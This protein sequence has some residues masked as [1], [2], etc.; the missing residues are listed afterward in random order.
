MVS[1]TIAVMHEVDIKV[2]VNAITFTKVCMINT[3]PFSEE[4]ITKV[5]RARIG[6]ALNI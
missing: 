3:G 4:N 1:I 2:N 5:A 6:H